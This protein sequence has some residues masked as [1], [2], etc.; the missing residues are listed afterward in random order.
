MTVPAGQEAGQGQGPGRKAE[1]GTRAPA[2]PGTVARPGRAAT[3]TAPATP[4]RPTSGTARLIR[5]SARAGTPGVAGAVGAGTRVATGCAGRKRPL[6]PSD[7]NGRPPPVLGSRGTSNQPWSPRAVLPGTSARQG[8]AGR[9]SGPGAPGVR[10]H[11]SGNDAFRRRRTSTVG[12]VQPDRPRR[13]PPRTRCPATGPDRSGSVF[14]PAGAG[15]RRPASGKRPRVPRR[16]AAHLGGICPTAAD[17]DLDVRNGATD[18]D[19]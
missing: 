12:T 6:A 8:A 11:Q 19:K 13:E 3:R 10:A 17:R 7:A 4:T 15:D 1:R 9:R 14:R 18:R 2:P 16:S 5:P